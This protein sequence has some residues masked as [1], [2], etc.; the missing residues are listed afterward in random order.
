MR[1]NTIPIISVLGNRDYDSGK[2]Y[3]FA[4][5]KIKKKVTCEVGI[6]LYYIVL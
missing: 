6:L 5:Q 4:R 3:C 1:E 2:P